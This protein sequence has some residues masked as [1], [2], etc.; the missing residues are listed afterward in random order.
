[1]TIT[2]PGHGQSRVC[3]QP[4]RQHWRELRGFWSDPHWRAQAEVGR[5]E[6]HGALDGGEGP[7]LDSLSVR[8]CLLYGHT[9]GKG[10]VMCVVS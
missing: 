5:H 7:G 6:P 4:P 9:H 10:R 1:V 8:R 3:A 2:E